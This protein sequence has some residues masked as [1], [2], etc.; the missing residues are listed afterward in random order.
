[1]D[2]HVIS[3]SRDGAGFKQRSAFQHSTFSHSLNE[4]PLRRST[5][6]KAGS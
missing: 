4:Q 1:V 2:M 3:L 6:E 5:V